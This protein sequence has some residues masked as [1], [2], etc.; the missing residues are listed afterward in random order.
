MNRQIIETTRYIAEEVSK[1]DGIYIMGDP[2]VSV[3]AIGKSHFFPKAIHCC[4]ILFILILGTS[5]SMP[6]IIF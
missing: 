3:V 2:E 5:F 4:H 6:H 1:I